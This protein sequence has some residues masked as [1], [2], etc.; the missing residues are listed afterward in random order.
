MSDIKETTTTAETVPEVVETPKET[1]T[2]AAKETTTE[3]VKDT[4]TEAEMPTITEAAKEETNG[5]SNG[6]GE[7][8]NGDSNG[9]AK[10]GD[11]NG[12]K[13]EA[14]NGAAKNGDAVAKEGNGHTETS[15]EDKEA[16]TKR[17]ADDTTTDVE[18]VPVSAE[19]IAKLTE[20]DN[21]IEEIKEATA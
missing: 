9:E 20:K 4:T 13:V 12:D 21:E 17:K 5:H 11:S 2:E 14:T 7:A 1:T 8:K 16:A 15:E 10:N 18:P 19:K 6:N 3:A